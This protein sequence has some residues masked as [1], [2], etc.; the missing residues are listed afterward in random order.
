M[1]ARGH[2]EVPFNASSTVSFVTNRVQVLKNRVKGPHELIAEFPGCCIYKSKTDLPDQDAI[3]LSIPPLAKVRVQTSALSSQQLSEAT[4]VAQ[5]DAYASFAAPKNRAW[6]MTAESGN[7]QSGNA[8]TGLDLPPGAYRFW[9]IHPEKSLKL[10]TRQEIGAGVTDLQ[11]SGDGVSEISREDA[12]LT[13]KHGTTRFETLDETSDFDGDGIPNQ[14][15]PKPREFSNILFHE[16]STINARI[17]NR[18]GNKVVFTG[19][20]GS[21]YSI[22][23]IPEGDQP[24]QPAL[25]EVLGVTLELEPGTILEVAFG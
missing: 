20:S 2:I 15:D 8:L 19:Y 5:R 14:I 24:T 3:S 1:S 17:V 23:V 9:L 7:F 4:L 21:S 11:F 16:D 22:E 10:E 6:R 13:L 25:V 18:G 12:D